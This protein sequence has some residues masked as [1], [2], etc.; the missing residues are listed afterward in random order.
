MDLDGCRSVA[1]YVHCAY[2]DPNT[3]ADDLRSEHLRAHCSVPIFSEQSVD[4][5]SSLLSNTGGVIQI[6]LEQRAIEDVFLK[7]MK[8]RG[9]EVDG[10]MTPTSI[11]WANGLQDPKAHALRVRSAARFSSNAHEL[12]YLSFRS[13]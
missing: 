9:L 12:T 13:S 7:S 6:T 1:V 11:E 3:V 10:G 8:E 4:L 5:L 2:T